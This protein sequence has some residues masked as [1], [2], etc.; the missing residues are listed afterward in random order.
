MVKLLWMLSRE[1]LELAE[2]TAALTPVQVNV[3][4]VPLPRFT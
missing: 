3:E 4:L 1:K 2:Q